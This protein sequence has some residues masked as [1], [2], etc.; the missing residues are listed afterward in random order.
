MA[1]QLG[2]ESMTP[3]VTARKAAAITAAGGEWHVFMIGEGSYWIGC[4]GPDGTH[5]WA[6]GINGTHPTRYACLDT[7]AAWLRIHAKTD[8]FFVSMGQK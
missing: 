2:I 5:Y 1:E 3:T 6:R 8:S 7:A 4:V